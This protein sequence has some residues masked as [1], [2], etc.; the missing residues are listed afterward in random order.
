MS[1]QHGIQEYTSQESK[2]LKL[3]QAGYV[4][5]ATTTSALHHADEGHYTAVTVL[6]DDCEVSFTGLHGESEVMLAAPV[7]AGTTIYGAWERV[8]IKRS[9][10]SDTSAIVYKG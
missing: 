4:F 9:G 1:K 3:G 2:N 5:L 10:S 6:E 7:A 8:S